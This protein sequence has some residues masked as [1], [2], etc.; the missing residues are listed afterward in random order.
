MRN[1]AADPPLHGSA[2][3][4][5]SEIRSIDA[6]LLRSLA[7]RPEP[8]P[9][10]GAE[11]VVQIAWLRLIERM[12]VFEGRSSLR[13]YVHGIA[14]NVQR[15][16]WSRAVRSHRLLE[17]YRDDADEHELPD[18]EASIDRARDRDRLR[19]AIGK[20]GS[21]DRWLVEQRLVEELPYE[22]IL[23]EYRRRFPGP[24]STIQGLRTAFFHARRRLAAQVAAR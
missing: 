12:H 23:P 10:F 9:M 7:R 22:Q 8:D 13:T 5:Q 19:H 20:L 3:E 16:A 2:A 15:E 21:R 18:R 17:A 14:R 24:I 4:W 1:L 11:D 6:Q